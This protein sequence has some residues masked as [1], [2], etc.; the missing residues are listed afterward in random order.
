MFERSNLIPGCKR[1][2]WIAVK[3]QFDAV[4]DFIS[5]IDAVS[6]REEMGL[7]EMLRFVPGRKNDSSID[8]KEQPFTRNSFSGDDDGRGGRFFRPS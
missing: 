5:E 2:S 7:S 1:D 3:A 8:S 4:S 6:G